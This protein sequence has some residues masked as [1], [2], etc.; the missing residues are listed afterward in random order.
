MAVTKYRF[1]SGLLCAA[2][3]T[4]CGAAGAGPSDVSGSSVSD[5]SVSA[6]L[7]SNTS[8]LEELPDH[9]VI[10]FEL[11][12]GE[13]PEGAVVE[14]TW[15]YPVTVDNG[16]RLTLRLRCEAEYRDGSWYYGVKAMDLL[17]G[18]TYLHT[19]SIQLA[20][21]AARFQ[22]GWDSDEAQE[23]THCWEPDGNLT[24]EDLNFDGTPDLRLLWGTGV[25]NSRYLCWLW[26]SDFQKFIFAFS[27]V[28]YDIQ[29]DPEKE[30]IVT[31]ARDAQ[32][33]ITNCYG[34]DVDGALRM[35][36]TESVTAEMG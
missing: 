18:E 33:H 1:L 20:D 14:Y 8:V 4:G 27:L 16:R 28:G 29:V 30:R 13:V 21:A 2:L 25:V 26:D 32:T 10:P 9:G 36:G 11:P 22:E 15:D 6:P 17:E 24:I 35:V 7:I 31:T 12:R 23:Q 19:L 3:L 5:T 34:Y